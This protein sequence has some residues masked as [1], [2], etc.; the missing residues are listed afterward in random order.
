MVV[1]AHVCASIVSMLQPPHG[2]HSYKSVA[3]LVMW[4]M[5]ASLD[6]SLMAET[7]QNQCSPSISLASQQWR[8]IVHASHTICKGSARIETKTPA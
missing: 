1:C 8:Y 2:R 4:L 6:A 3:C 5:E 7:R